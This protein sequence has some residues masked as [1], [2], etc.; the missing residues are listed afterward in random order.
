MRIKL[1]NICYFI[2][3]LIL[4]NI[5]IKQSPLLYGTLTSIHDIL[6]LV[7]PLLYY[8]PSFLLIPFFWSPS[9]THLYFRTCLF[10]CLLFPP[11]QP[12]YK[13]FAC[14]SCILF[15]FQYTGTHTCTHKSRFYILEKMCDFCLSKLDLFLLR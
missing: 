6:L 1:E 7:I 9:P 14:L 11:L 13:F 15:Y 5:W 4:I 10:Y 2:C 8:L 3:L 12:P